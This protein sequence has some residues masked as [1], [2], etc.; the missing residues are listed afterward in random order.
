MLSVF[1]IPYNSITTVLR[2][3]FVKDAQDGSGRS[4]RE[5][6]EHGFL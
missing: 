3:T 1:T 5:L 4:R 2:L 6:R